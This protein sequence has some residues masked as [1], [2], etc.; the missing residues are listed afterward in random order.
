MAVKALTGKEPDALMADYRNRR[1]RRIQGMKEAV[2]IEV[3]TTLLNP[4]FVRER[5]KGDEGTA[6]MFGET[7]RNIFG[8][9]VTRQS[10][11]D[12]NLYDDLYRMYVKDEQQ[13]GI[14]EYFKQKNPAAYQAMTATLLES[15]RK[16]YW[17]PSAPQLRATALLHAAIT[18]DCGAACTDFVCNNPQLQAFVEGHLPADNRTGYSRQMSLTKSRQANVKATILERQHQGAS[19]P[20]SVSL[21]PSSVPMTIL[22]LVA[23]MLTTLVAVVIYLRQRNGNRR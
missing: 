23:I 11:L 2:D 1:N 20:S 14:R 3:R 6:Q 18:Q 22:G 9:S 21:Q 8:W 12:K 10:A 19:Q 5:M 13:L 16:G 4:N 15:A 7:F 17:K